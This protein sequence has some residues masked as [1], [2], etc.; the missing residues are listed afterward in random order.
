MLLFCNPVEIYVSESESE[1]ESEKSADRKAQ[2]SPV[3]GT[4]AFLICA[5][6]AADF[7]R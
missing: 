1:S 2:I 3:S 4:H 7:L 5:F 6:R